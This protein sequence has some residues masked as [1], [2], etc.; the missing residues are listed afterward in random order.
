M[1]IINF[2]VMVAVLAGIFV[3]HI[4][5][6]KQREAQYNETQKKHM[7]FRRACAIPIVIGSIWVPLSLD[8]PRIPLRNGEALPMELLIWIGIWLLLH[9]AMVVAGRL[10]FGEEGRLKPKKEKS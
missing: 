4:K 2:L 1:M 6:G 5:V 9:G 8:L 10:I 3:W 7:T